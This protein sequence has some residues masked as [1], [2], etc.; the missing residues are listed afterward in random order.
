MTSRYV[1]QLSK[2]ERALRMIALRIAFT[3]NRQGS[4]AAFARLMEISAPA[5][6]NYESGYRIGI[7]HALALRAKTGVTL[8]WIYCGVETPGPLMQKLAEARNV[9]LSAPKRSQKPRISRRQ[10]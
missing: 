2:S 9:A 3:G 5:W 7:D 10:D 4:Q 8:D 6:N 1:D